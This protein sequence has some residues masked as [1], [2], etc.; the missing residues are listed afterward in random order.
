[1]QQN[2]P[3]RGYMLHSLQSFQGFGLMLIIL[4]DPEA[5]YLKVM[6]PQRSEVMQGFISTAEMYRFKDSGHQDFEGLRACTDNFKEMGEVGALWLREL[7][8]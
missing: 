2:H 8:A 7:M 3:R 4:H 6:V 5:T 1:M